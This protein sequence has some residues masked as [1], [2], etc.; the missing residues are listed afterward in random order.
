MTS[1]I[2]VAPG[3]PADQGRV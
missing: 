1:T 3:G 2:T